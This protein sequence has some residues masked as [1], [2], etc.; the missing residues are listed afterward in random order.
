MDEKRRY[1]VDLDGILV[2]TTIKPLVP[3]LAREIERQRI[4]AGLDTDELLRALREERARYMA[5]MYGEGQIREDAPVALE[6]RDIDRNKAL[7]LRERL[8]G[9]AEEWDSPEMDAYDH[10]D[11]DHTQP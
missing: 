9:F 3:D 6:S 8:A 5:E 4:E 7:E 10:Y 11:P 1:L 2:E